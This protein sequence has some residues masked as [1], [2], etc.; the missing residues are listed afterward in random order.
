MLFPK[1]GSKARYIPAKI[2][3]KNLDELRERCGEHGEAAVFRAEH[4]SVTSWHLKEGEPQ[5]GQ[6]LAL[7][8]LHDSEMRRLGFSRHDGSPWPEGL[9]AFDPEAQGHLR[10]IA[11]EALEAWRAAGSPGLMHNIARTQ[12]LVNSYRLIAEE[13]EEKNMEYQGETA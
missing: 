4:N 13:E 10:A 9:D 3:A 8:L 2:Q 6:T 1:N 11:H 7:R 5:P 12:Q